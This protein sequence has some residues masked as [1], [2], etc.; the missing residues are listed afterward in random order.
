MNTIQIDCF[1]ALAEHQNFSK[2]A[3]QMY[4]A[5]PTLSKYIKSLEEELELILIDRSHRKICL[6]P[7]GQLLYDYFK[8]AREQF[9]DVVFRAYNL[10]KERTSLNVV[11]LEGLDTDKIIKPLLDY[12]FFN[13]K[14]NISFEQFPAYQIPK[15]LEN[16]KYDLA[17]TMKDHLTSANKTKKKILYESI[18]PSR[19]FLYYSVLHPVNQLARLATF[20]DFKD[21]IFY[22]PANYA[23][24]AGDDQ[25]QGTQPVEMYE[26]WLG[27]TPNVRIV[28]SV[29]S[30]LPNLLSGKG[31]SLLSEHNRIGA[32]PNIRSIP[33]PVQSDV[34][35]AWCAD[36]E[37]DLIRDILE[38]NRDHPLNESTS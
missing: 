25:K 14:A 38:F 31:V 17:V 5:Q 10:E 18:M 22:I 11:L 30:V 21:D 33:T 8:E 12:Q 36:R 7:E 29:S 15:F 20:A 2:T 32:S 1:M 28:D 19:L 13:G 37:T 26:E 34:V 3:E 9:N 16:G 23:N 6:T 4:I 27:Y 35:Y 24:A